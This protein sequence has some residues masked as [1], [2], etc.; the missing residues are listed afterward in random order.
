MTRNIMKEKLNSLSIT[1][2]QMTAAYSSEVAYLILLHRGSDGWRHG[3][4]GWSNKPPSRARKM[5]SRFFKHRWVSPASSEGAIKRDWA[6]KWV[7]TR[8]EHGS[9]S[10]SMMMT[11]T[12]NHGISPADI[13]MDQKNENEMLPIK[14]SMLFFC[15]EFFFDFFWISYYWALLVIY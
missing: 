13:T 3:T 15:S 7:G 9:M 10:N 11:L 14:E 5:P 4:R 8:V 2:H 6:W 1:S 12:A